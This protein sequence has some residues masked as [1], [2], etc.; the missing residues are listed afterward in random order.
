[1]R[2]LT[3]FVVAGLMLATVVPAEA[4]LNHT[5]PIGT[6]VTLPGVS[7][8]CETWGQHFKQATLKVVGVGRSPKGD[9]IYVAGTGARPD[10]G[11]DSLVVASYDASTGSQRWMTRAPTNLPTDARGMTVTR[12]GSRVYVTGFIT[13][14]PN[15]NSNP[16]AYY[17]TLALSASSGRP[18]W[19]ATYPGIGAN[20][21]EGQAITTTARGDRVLVTGFSQHVCLGCQVTPTDWTTVAYSSAGKALWAAR[22]SGAAGGQNQAFRVAIDPKSRL[23]FVTGKSERPTLQPTRE[24][25]LA[26]AAYKLSNGDQVW[27]RRMSSGNDVTP[28]GVATSPS[29]AAVYNIATGEDLVGGGSAAHKYLVAAY[30]ATDGKLLWSSSYRDASGLPNDAGAFALSPSGDRIY[31]TGTGHAPSSP[32]P[33]EAAPLDTMTST[34]AF[35]TATGRHIWSAQ[36]APDGGSAGGNA[37]AVSPN[38]RSIYVGGYSGPLGAGFAGAG[39][40]T[41][42]AYTSAGAQSWVASYAV[43]DPS[44]LGGGSVMGIVVDPKGTAIYSAGLSLPLGSAAGAVEA[45]C[46]LLR[47]AA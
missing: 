25:D 40:F 41:T 39:Y 37:I 17:Y 18:L 46:M 1:M 9:R 20:D 26:T 36:Y 28:V 47:Y 35:S 16:F 24:Y 10:N 13:F 11:V 45:D 30:R 19:S 12:D 34:V 23:V 14:R 43:R 32:V 22:W 7:D 15:L 3:G 2:R 42:T 31:V 27:V 5:A 21:N 33:S 44:T 38:G 29:G 6:C 4:A 8:K